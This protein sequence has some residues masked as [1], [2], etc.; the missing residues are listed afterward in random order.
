M[1][2]A[3]RAASPALHVPPAAA[4]LPPGEV[5]W[6][7]EARLPLWLIKGYE[8]NAKRAALVAAAEAQ[9]EAAKGEVSDKPPV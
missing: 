2:Q 7:S 4:K 6:V 8:E 9:R 3:A 5:S 1:L